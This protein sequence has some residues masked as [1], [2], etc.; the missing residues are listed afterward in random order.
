MIGGG[1]LTVVPVVYWPPPKPLLLGE[2]ITC[3]GGGDGERDVAVLAGPL[4]LTGRR[5]NALP[6]DEGGAR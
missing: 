1:I 4:S 3:D 6:E 2:W 5:R